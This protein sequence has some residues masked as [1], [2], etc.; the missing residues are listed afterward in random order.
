M[1][2]SRPHPPFSCP[3]RFMSSIFQLADQWTG[4]TEAAEYV[5]FLSSSYAT[6]FSD[7]A[8]EDELQFP[9]A[10]AG[11]T[12]AR[13]EEAAEGAD[14][15]SHRDATRGAAAR[16]RRRRASAAVRWQANAAAVA[17]ASRPCSSGPCHTCSA[18]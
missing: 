14:V 6:V 10:W 7:L 18:E 15:V 8:A 1:K 2:L 3:L 12:G 4:S 9:D 17:R 13:G 16:Q 11:L 5:E